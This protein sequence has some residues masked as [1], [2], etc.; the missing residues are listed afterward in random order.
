VGTSRPDRS[1]SVLR[2]SS[3]GVPVAAVD[4]VSERTVEITFGE[5]GAEAYVFTFG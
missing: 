1:R 3:R 5:P 4:I 2:R